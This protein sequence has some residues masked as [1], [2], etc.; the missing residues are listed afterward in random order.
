MPNVIPQIFQSLFSLHDEQF[1]IM[2]YNLLPYFRGTAGYYNSFASPFTDRILQRS[3]A[4]MDITYLAALY[5]VVDFEYLDEYESR[6]ISERD[7]SSMQRHGG[8]GF[9]AIAQARYSRRFDFPR[10]I[11]LHADDRHGNPPERVQ[12]GRALYE[13]AGGEV[14]TMALDKRQTSVLESLERDARQ[15]PYVLVVEPIWILAFPTEGRR[16]N[17]NLILPSAAGTT[18]R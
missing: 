5:P 13:F 6:K 18:S 2:S 7:I 9:P 16:N 8:I 11:T 17:R 4:G 15:K 3:Y 1:K 14:D 10:D 12:S